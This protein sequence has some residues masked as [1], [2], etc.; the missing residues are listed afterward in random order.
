[1]MDLNLIK[2]LKFTL[3]VVKEA[4]RLKSPVASIALECSQEDGDGLS[5]VILS[6]GIKIPKGVY[7]WLNI[8]GIHHDERHFENPEEFKPSRWLQEE[9]HNEEER[10]S[11]LM[12]MESA[13]IAFGGGPRICPGMNLAFHEATLAIAFL[14]I[15]Y[16]M[17][18][19]CPVSEI[20]RVPN[21]VAM[22]NKMPVL[23]T[24]AKY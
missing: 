17:T 13:L 15:H 10:N 18:L 19:N 14:A 4:L 2:E 6:N 7:A 22:A 9:I 23:F 3:G 12:K 16:D 11:K 8:D 24:P 20:K 1:M 5:E 21:F